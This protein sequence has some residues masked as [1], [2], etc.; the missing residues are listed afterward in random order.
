MSRMSENID[1]D[2]WEPPEDRKAVVE[3]HMAKLA[4]TPPKPFEMTKA[5]RDRLSAFD[6]RE[7]FLEAPIGRISPTLAKQLRWTVG[8]DNQARDD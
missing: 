1:G 8:D 7:G 3:K 5:T 4:K 6:T 2:F